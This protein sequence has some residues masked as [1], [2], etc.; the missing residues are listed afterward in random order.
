VASERYVGLRSSSQT[1]SGQGG[2][3]RRVNP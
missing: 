3:A 2:S 1:L